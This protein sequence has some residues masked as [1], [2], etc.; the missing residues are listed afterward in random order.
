MSTAPAMS[1]EDLFKEAIALYGHDYARI[2][3]HMADRQ[4]GHGGAAALAASGAAPTTAAPTAAPVAGT[5]SLAPAPAPT[6]VHTA[7]APPAAC[8]I[9]IWSL[10]D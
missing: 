8:P 5:M 3:Q 6:M 7:A 1:T 2:Q 4:N 9:I 10:L